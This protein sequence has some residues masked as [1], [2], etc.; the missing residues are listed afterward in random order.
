MKRSNQTDSSF[1]RKDVIFKNRAS[2]L[3]NSSC[4]ERWS[5]CLLT[6]NIDRFVTTLMQ[7]SIE[8]W[9]CDF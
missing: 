2:Q 5:L 9:L 7:D 4:K 3:F 8:V 6:L 1:W